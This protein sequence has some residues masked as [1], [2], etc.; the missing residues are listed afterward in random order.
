M[1]GEFLNRCL[2]DQFVC[3]IRNP[4]TR[5]KRLSEDR[6]FQQALKVAIADEIATKEG[7]KVQQQL[8]QSVNSVSKN[9]SISKTSSV[10]SVSKNSAVRRRLVEIL[11]YLLFYAK[12]SFQTRLRLLSRIRTLVF[13]WK[14]WP[15]AIE[16]QI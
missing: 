13:I 10:D 8:T 2:R 16:V 6:T 3:G 1:S 12:V 9:P 5:K 14:C 7:V 15:R 11:V 4:A